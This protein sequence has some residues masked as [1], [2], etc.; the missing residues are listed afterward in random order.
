MLNEAA[1]RHPI[2]E[3]MRTSF[4]KFCFAICL[5]FAFGAQNTEAQVDV[6]DL[7]GQFGES[8]NTVY[9]SIPFL[10]INPDARSGGMGDVGLATSPDAAS[11]YWNAS[12][13]AFIDNDMGMSL[14]YTP[15]LKE[16]VNDIY[17]AY[18]TGYKKVDDI[19]SLGVSLRYF[20]LGDIQFTDINA[21][22]AGQFSPRELAFDVGYARKLGE[23]FSMGLTL[24]YAYSNLA[25][26]QNVN[27]NVIK[28]ATAAA[29]DI[30][31]F[32]TDDMLIGTSDAQLS[33][34]G[35]VSNI[36]NK[37]SYTE[38]EQ[39]DFIPINLGVGA[40][41][42][43]NFDEYNSIMIAADINKL[44]VP[45]PAPDSLS[46]DGTNPRDKAV[47]SGMFGSFN[48]APGGGKEEMQEL[49]YSFGLE[50]WYNK[51]F[52]VRVGHYNEHKY[53][54]NRKY[55]TVG[56]GLKYNIFGLNFSYIIPTT[57][58]RGTSPLDNTLR[59]SLLFDFNS[60]QADS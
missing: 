46:T 36:G 29:G 10:R 50:Y 4:L 58:N 9:T 49:M 59:F 32:Y 28:P 19:Q 40:A 25:K 16:L 1:E 31:F 42:E 45:T 56:L 60:E 39:K 15:W 14:T 34:G 23:K 55:M 27:G 53:K 11:M 13:L 54:G 37:V 6:G 2:Q 48:D 52:A 44:L 33:V 38:T 18:L 26:G 47:I 22:P 3:N 51:Q 5:C 21:E 20:S 35:A 12:K 41:L 8:V 43:L 57:Q 24:K 17:I 30:S 7:N